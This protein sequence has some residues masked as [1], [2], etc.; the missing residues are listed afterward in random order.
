ML[1]ARDSGSAA[2]LAGGFAQQLAGQVGRES[3]NKGRCV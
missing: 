2:G 1:D 3:G